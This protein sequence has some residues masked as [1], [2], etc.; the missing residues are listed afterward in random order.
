[1]RHRLAVLLSAV[2]VVPVAAGQKPAPAAPPVKKNPF[3]KLI[4]PWPTPEKQRERKLDA[5]ALPLFAS[6]EP[7]AVTLTADFKSVNKDRDPNSR[8]RYPASLTVDDAPID[9]ELRARG[10]LRRMSRTCDY[11]PLRLEFPKK[12]TKGGPFAKQE[13]VKLV[14]QC[15]GGRDYEQFI[16]KEYL[17]YQ[18]FNAITHSSFRARLARVSY[19][20]RATGKPSGTR[21]GI[22]LEDDGDVAKRMEGR[23][24]ELP[25]LMFADV[26]PDTLMPMMIFEYMIGN[27]DYSIHALHNVRIIQRP[28][29]SLHTVPYDFDISGLVNPPYAVPARGLMLKTVL[30][31][32]YRGP[33]K[34]Q[35]LVDPY[36]AN[37]VAKRDLIRAL[38]ESVPG[39]DKTTARE[40]RDYIDSFYGSIRSTKD[41]RSLFVQCSDK[42][43]M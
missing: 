4:E 15:S 18:M 23:V 8:T 29:K 25:R 41:V 16:L 31:R 10:H 22:F 12:V 36:V 28:D 9:V 27:T 39:M 6:S 43:T 34:R 3:L 7:L 2:L 11:V 42:P 21:V 38:P 37:F 26:A 5:E 24:V 30:D 20:D 14:V 19:V 1:M 35:E 17:A 32:M 33:C 40:A 13:A